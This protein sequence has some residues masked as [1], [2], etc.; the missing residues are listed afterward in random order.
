MLYGQPN[1]SQNEEQPQ[2]NPYMYPPYPYPIPPHPHSQPH[3]IPHPQHITHPH[4][5][6]QQITHPHQI[7]HP[8]SHPI[9]MYQHP[10]IPQYPI[11]YQ[12]TPPSSTTIQKTKQENIAKYL[13][14]LIKQELKKFGIPS[15]SIEIKSL[16]ED[17]VKYRKTTITVVIKEMKE[18]E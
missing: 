14:S 11:G 4:S 13:E 1:P 16:P 3:Q 7:P 12:I 5:Q 10:Q 17:T 6:P 18:T 15:S 9:M 2:P 8:Q